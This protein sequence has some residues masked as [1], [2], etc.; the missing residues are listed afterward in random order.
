MKKIKVLLSALLVIAIVFANV[1]VFA[2]YGDYENTRAIKVA[3]VGDSITYGAGVSDRATEAYASI[4]QEKLGDEYIVG[5]FG[6][7]A[8]SALSTALSARATLYLS[9]SSLI[10]PRFLMPAVSMKIYF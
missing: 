3:F 7:S 8:T 10:L 5:N 6:V 9:T 4:I 2:M 1:A